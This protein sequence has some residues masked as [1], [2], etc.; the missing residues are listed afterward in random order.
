MA[1]SKYHE[2]W[3]NE[4]NTSTPVSAAALDHI[5]GGI[6]DAA[7]TADAARAGDW[8]PDVADV[9]NLPASKITTGTLA[10][11]RI[12]SLPYRADDWTPAV[13]DVPNL[14][15][16]KITSGAFNADRIPT[17]PLE[18]VTDAAS[19]AALTALET[20][21]AALEAAGD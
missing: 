8:T 2:A 6:A 11:A 18:K 21:V 3:E 4:P 13:A 16:S 17:L 1:Y 7:A 5:E 15:A 9:P 14:A 10:A 12:P 20:R 19:A